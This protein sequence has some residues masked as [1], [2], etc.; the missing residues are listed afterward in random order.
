MEPG[1]S[2]TLDGVKLAQEIRHHAAV[3]RTH[4]DKQLRRAH[5]SLSGLGILM[6]KHGSSFHDL[7]AHQIPKS[8]PGYQPDPGTLQTCRELD[9]LISVSSLPPLRPPTF[10][11]RIITQRI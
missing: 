11:S 9:E 2:P 6:R 4:A 1:D 10:L 8:M 7:V 5:E 3:S